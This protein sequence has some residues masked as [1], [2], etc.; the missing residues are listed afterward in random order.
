MLCKICSPCLSFKSETAGWEPEGRK[1]CRSGVKQTNKS[2][3]DCRS[4]GLQQGSW[5]NPEINA[6]TVGKTI[7]SDLKKN[8][9]TIR[10][11]YKQTW[12]YHSLSDAVKP[13]FIVILIVSALVSAGVICPHPRGSAWTVS[14][15][16]YLWTCPC[17]RHPMSYK[18]SSVHVH[19]LLM[20]DWIVA[21]ITLKDYLSY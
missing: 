19:R 13:W 15:Y 3:W 10:Y 9:N 17:S 11:S 20:L 5:I 16:Q 4:K 2:S 6:C 7:K 1:L 12:K 8:P 21:L 18:H 14:T